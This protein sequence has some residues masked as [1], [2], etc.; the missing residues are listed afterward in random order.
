LCYF[1]HS[2]LNN[3][4]KNKMT[5]ALNIVDAAAPLISGVISVLGYSTLFFIGLYFAKKIGKKDQYEE[6]NEPFDR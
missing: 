5:N 4:T 6:E 1:T 2:P 3:Q